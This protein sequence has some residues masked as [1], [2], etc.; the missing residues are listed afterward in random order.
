MALLT[1]ATLVYQ[2]CTNKY[3]HIPTPSHPRNIT[4]KLFPVTKISIKPVNN[5]IYLGLFILMN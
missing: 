5:E 1:A 2:K 4:K 3:E